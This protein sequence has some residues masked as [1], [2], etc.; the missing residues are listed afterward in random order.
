MSTGFK[1]LV[2]LHIL[3]VIAGF[4]ALAYNALYMNLA[5]RRPAGGTGAVIEVNRLVSGL[6]EM[7]VYAALL[8]GVGAVSAGHPRIG[9]SDA[10]VSAALAVYLVDV[11]ILHGWIRPHQRQYAA[12]VARLE[13]PADGAQSRD[14]DVAAL[15][16]LERQVSVGW[17]VF[18]LLVVGA[19]YLMVFKPG[20]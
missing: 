9:F 15:N 8:F 1:I 18:N 2:F 14:G 16:K 5:Q 3:C 11:G 13:A 4:G 17:A 19:V 20:S 12:T 10:W 7:F 6:A